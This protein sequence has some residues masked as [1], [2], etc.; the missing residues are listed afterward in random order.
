MG[1][2]PAP[3]V[4]SLL[5]SFADP[6]FPAHNLPFKAKDVAELGLTGAN[7]NACDGRTT[8]N[9]DVWSITVE[10]PSFRNCCL[11]SISSWLAT[12][13]AEG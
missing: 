2:P 1:P 11:L 4:D 9:F 10:S 3:N 7:V 8:L 6:P 13:D 12:S 5:P